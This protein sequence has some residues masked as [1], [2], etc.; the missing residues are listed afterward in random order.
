MPEVT[1]ANRV[2]YIMDYEG[3][4]LDLDGVV[5]LFSHLIES[6]LAW[7]LQGSYGRQARAFIEN[8]F[9]SDTGEVNQDAIDEA[10][11]AA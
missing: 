4:E 10:L 3:G 6:G 9:I 1:V 7:S 5:S 8:G 2:N 11:E